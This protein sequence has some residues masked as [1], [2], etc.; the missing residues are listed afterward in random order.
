MTL[1]LENNVFVWRGGFEP[2][3]LPK[4]AGFRW[5]AANKRWHTADVTAAAKLR[6]YADVTATAAFEQTVAVHAAAK[7]ASRATDARIDI[8]APAGLS[9]LPFQKAGIA[10]AHDRANVLIGD[11]M[12]LGKTIQAIGALNLDPTAKSI[13]ILCPA[14]L[15]NNWKRELEKW[16][17]VPRTIGIAETKVTPDTEIV[18]AHYDIFSRNCLSRAL[19]REHTWDVLI[20]DEAH[21]CKNGDAARTQK[22]IGG[23]SETGIVA[24]RKIFLTGTPLTNRPRDLFSLLHA[25]DPAVWTDFWSFAKRYCG[26]Y[27]SKFGWNFDGASNLSEL[28]DKLRSTIMVRRLKSQVLTELPAKRRQIIEITANDIVAAERA[29]TDSYEADLVALQIKAELAKAAD[30]DRAYEDA[31][32]ELGAKERVAFHQ[33]ALVRH[34]TAL[35][36]VPYVIEHLKELVEEQNVKVICF[37][38]HRDVID[39][40]GAAFPGSEIAHGNYTTDERDASVRRF[41]TDD[42]CR[43]IVCGIQAMGVGHTLTASSTVVF[44]EL[45]YVP[46]DVTQAEDR[47]HRIG[48]HNSVLVQHIVLDGSIDAKIA[49]TLVSKQAVADAALDVKNVASGDRSAARDAA[50]LAEAKE[51]VAADVLK[52]AEERAERD[53]LQATRREEAA[54]RAVKRTEL[55]AEGAKLTPAQVEAIHT[56]LKVVAS[57]DQDRARNLN[58]VGFNKIDTGIGVFLAG[59]PRLDAVFAGVG[60]R[61]VIKYQRQFGAE[62]LATIKG[63]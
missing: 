28:Q 59:Q 18:I 12:G 57:Y 21:Y 11:D 38:H 52:A 1:T 49:Q 46:A 32:K 62:L 9:Y 5:D 58:G 40:I 8:P 44:A 39:Q 25:L 61:I 30:D 22:I 3:H 35:K 50:T 27:R 24:R 26:A 45:S 15:R 19:L 7:I 10:F 20:L 33:I 48:Q 42:K 43:L 41:Q 13:L 54:T 51:A 37:A 14:S 2:R 55:A 31:V 17:V 34:E 63:E 36:K 16:L 56:A 6:E 4:A 60:R 47:A 23:K 29:Q 53:A